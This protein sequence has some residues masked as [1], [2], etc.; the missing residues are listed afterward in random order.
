MIVRVVA[1]I[2]LQR[3][4]IKPNHEISTTKLVYMK[5]KE[6]KT[7]LLKAVCPV[8]LDIAGFFGCHQNFNPLFNPAIFWADDRL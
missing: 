7:V 4:S 5:T 8:S 2:S 6:P 3:Y 1:A